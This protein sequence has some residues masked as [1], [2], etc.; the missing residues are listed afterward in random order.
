MFLSNILLDFFFIMLI[1]MISMS[2]S[3]FTGSYSFLSLICDLSI[4]YSLVMSY[5]VTLPLSTSVKNKFLYLRSFEE[6]ELRK[7]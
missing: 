2:S 4:D 3:Y 6:M 7:I 5:L 1:S